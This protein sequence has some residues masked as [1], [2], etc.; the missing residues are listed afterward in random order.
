MMKI[1]HVATATAIALVAVGC[2][3]MMQREPAGPSFFVTSTG[4]GKGADF[5]GLAGADQHCQKLA[6]AAG[7]PNRTWRAYLSSAATKSTKAVTKEK[8]CASRE[9]LN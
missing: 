6:G 4:S 9:A 5:G 7:L 8:T 1:T 2:A 3:S